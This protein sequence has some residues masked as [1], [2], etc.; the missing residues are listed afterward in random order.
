MGWLHLTL[1]R[2]T[3]RAPQVR[4]M[5]LQALGNIASGTQEGMR[6]SL[7]SWAP[8]A[9]LSVIPTSKAGDG[10]LLHAAARLLRAQAA[11]PTG[12]V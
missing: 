12:K 8:R 10:K 9:A 5:A 3:L 11:E 1:Y 2:W 7:C 4:T 6:A